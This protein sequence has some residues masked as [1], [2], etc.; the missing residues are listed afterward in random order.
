MADNITVTP[1]TGATIAAENLGGALVQRVKPVLGNLDVDGGD[2]SSTN[3]MPVTGTGTAGTPATGVVTVQGSASGTPI[4]I[5]GS[6]T[7]T[8]LS[9]GA[10][11]ATPPVDATYVGASVTTSSPTYTTGQMNALSLTTSGGLRVDGS[12][13]TQPVSG[14][15]VANAGTNLN[16][17]ALA[18]ESG[19]HLASL[20]TKLPSQ[21]QALAAASTPVVLPALQITALTPPTT[22]T[23]TQT[24]GSNLHTAVDSLPSIPAG[25][26]AIGSVSVSNFPGTQPVSGTVTA[27]AGTGTF[28]VS[29]TALPLPTG[30]A[31]SAKQP[32]LGVA[33]TP[34]T[35][36]LTVQGAASMTAL[37]VDGSG[38]TQPVSAA[39]LPLPAGA[40]TSALQT[41][42]NASLT[43]LATNLPPQG[44]ALAAASTPVV[45]PATQITALTPPTTVT[46]TQATGTNLHTVIDS[47]SVTVSNFPATQPISAASLPLPT[48][49]STSALQTS[50]NASLSTIATNLPP[51][52]QALAAASLPVVL[53]AAQVT[54]LTPPT[55][56][57][58]TQ[59]TGTNLHAVVDSGTVTA[60]AGTGTFAVSATSLPLPTGAATA[61]LQTSGNASLA[62]IAALS[63]AQGS[64]TSGETGVLMQGAVTTSAPSYTTAQTNPLS[65]TTAGALRTDASGTNQPVISA[66]SSS[67][68]TI[69]GNGNIIA[70]GALGPYAGVVF[71][72][73]GTWSSTLS[74]Q[75]SNDGTNYFPINAVNLG[76]TA[77]GSIATITTNGLYYAPVGYTNLELV[78]S[79]YVS[80]TVSCVCTFHS[81]APG[82]LD[83]ATGTVLDKSAT[84]TIAALNG[85]VV[86]PING[87]STVNV[88]IS[89]TWSATLTFEGQSGDGIWNILAASNPAGGINVSTATTNNTY[90]LGVGGFTQVRVIATAYTSGTA[91]I[92]MNGSSGDQQTLA[93][94][95]NGNQQIVGNIADGTADA[96]NSVKVG[97]VFNTTLPAL[98]NGERGPLQL[99][100]TSHL[101]VTNAPLD[102]A[103]ATY[104]A[105]ITGLTVAAAPTDIFT[106]TGSATKTIRVTRI[107]FAGSQTTAT[108]RDILLIKRSAA[109]TG[110]TSTT[111]TNVPHDSTFA[112]GTA[113]VRAYTVNPTGL[114]ATVGT[115]RSHKILIATTTTDS[116][117]LIMD[118]GTRP[119]QAL[120]VRGVAEV[121]A[122]NL[123]GI[124]SAGSSLDISIE[125][126]EE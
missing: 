102:G 125:W 77:A 44:Q 120:V 93:V 103:K 1:G 67:S 51:Q 38:V 71:A 37:K 65:L 53:T 105:A 28:A 91:A 56:V 109:N 85:T 68:G 115:I 114:G 47:G 118:F 36:V 108:Q 2:I 83:N 78:S 43:T 104:S 5:S 26:N 52:G 124:A 121:L 4:P 60:N 123:N 30:A 107:T 99:D 39:S 14:T 8:N 62:T 75:G 59:A 18:L 111:E 76:N 117:N 70:V 40:A 22:V 64:T 112:A 6:I 94:D 17:S 100:S 88:S 13:V 23:V 9:I 61:A 10:T 106:I 82:I 92:T 74:I 48:G 49:A 3:P 90:V 95:A 29:A 46:V 57:T 15:V 58:V 97:G 96:G 33:G 54:T 24:T 50:G 87:I 7:A 34:S 25:S 116:D 32:A 31:T 89:G 113:T 72:I 11:G 69:A 20:D 73:S 19:G 21:G 45:L 41:S 27:N 122:I 110:G 101:I 119:A 63:L 35:D 84:G 81:T 98:T 79:N 55:T 42:G 16:T 80:G 66:T 12:S 126:T 86:L